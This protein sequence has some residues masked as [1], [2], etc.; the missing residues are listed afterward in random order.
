MH[1]HMS[2]RTNAGTFPWLT[3][4]KGAISKK[5]ALLIADSRLEPHTHQHGG[6]DQ[7][8]IGLI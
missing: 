4:V 8:E 7:G 1:I 2:L 5:P 6:G 3:R